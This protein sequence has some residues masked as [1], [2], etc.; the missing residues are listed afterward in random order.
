MLLVSSTLTAAE[1]PVSKEYQLKAAFLY[2]FT[3]FVEW[4]P[5]RFADNTSPIVVAVV[6]RNPF[7]EELENVVKGRAVNGR[8]I[9]IKLVITPDEAAGAHL[10]FVPSGEEN[11][12]P[13]AAVQRD[14]LLAVGES[15]VFAAQGGAITFVQVGGK[16]RFEINIG[17]AER[18]HVKISTQLLKLANVVHRRPEGKP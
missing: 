5:A 18:A 17:A 14:A 13:A 2:N 9:A 3:K 4:P 6:G 10:L 1:T 12:L 8:A 7:G 15:E 16:M 11:R